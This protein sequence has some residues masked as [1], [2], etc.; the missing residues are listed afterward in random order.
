[1]IRLAG[2]LLI[3]TVSAGAAAAQGIGYWVCEA[4]EWVG[5]G[6]PLHPMPDRA[7]DEQRPRPDT[8]SDCKAGGGTWARGGLS[9]TPLCIMPTSDGGRLCGTAR[10]CEGNCIVSPDVGGG[11]V[12]GPGRCSERDPVFGCMTLML[13]GRPQ[14]ICID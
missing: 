4:G 8:E 3:V 10:E 2:L 5:V 11:P 1:M 6:S 7:C 13:E 14:E 9:P 12:A